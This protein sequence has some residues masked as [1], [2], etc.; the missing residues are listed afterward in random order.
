MRIRKL[1]EDK[2]VNP[3]GKP[4]PRTGWCIILCGGSG[5]GKSTAYENIVNIDA[6]HLDVDEVKNFWLK[7]SQIEGNILTTADGMKYDLDRENISEPYDMSNGQ[8]TD[9]VHRV[10]KPVAR[11]RQNS[12]LTGASTADKSRLPNVVFDITGDEIHKFVEII[13]TVKQIGYKIAIVYVTGE[14]SQAIEQNEMRP[15]KVAKDILLT[16][17]LDVLY[18]MNKLFTSDIIDTVDE[19]Y[20]IVQFRCDITDVHGRLDYIKKDNVY[21]VKVPGKKIMVPSQITARM[22]AELDKLISGYYD[23]R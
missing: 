6:K 9:F 3:G 7:S 17:H 10:T 12:F 20:I 5:M 16:K 8:F 23:K 21:R 1:N 15:R 14:I 4:F 2:T 11:A 18:T 22:T 19:V 13:D